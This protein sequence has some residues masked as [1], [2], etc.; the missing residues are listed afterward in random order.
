M[1]MTTTL[2]AKNIKLI[3]D[4][5]RAIQ[6]NTQQQKLLAQQLKQMHQ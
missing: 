1:P 3:Q 2:D 4:L 5:T 6:S